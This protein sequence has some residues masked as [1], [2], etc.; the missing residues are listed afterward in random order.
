MLET[1]E[2]KTAREK[3]RARARAFLD[4]LNGLLGTETVLFI[5]PIPETGNIFC[6]RLPEE[7][8]L[9]VYENLQKQKQQ[10][11]REEQLTAGYEVH[12]YF[13][14][15]DRKT[16][17]KGGPHKIS[18]SQAQKYINFLSQFNPMINP[19]NACPVVYQ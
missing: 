15:S 12:K 16:I 11:Q 14:P 2:K 3:R 4:Q 19:A 7:K 5:Y 1:L 17:P 8:A 10:S 13:I 9:D 6:L 18:D